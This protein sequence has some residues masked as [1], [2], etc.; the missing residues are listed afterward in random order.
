MGAL[1]K[2][3]EDADERVTQPGEEGEASWR[4]EPQ[5]VL[6]KQQRSFLGGAS[7]WQQNLPSRKNVLCKDVDG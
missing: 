6:S 4:K 3:R 5:V 2:Y 7:Y 1:L